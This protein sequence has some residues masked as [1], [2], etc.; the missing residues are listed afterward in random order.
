MKSFDGVLIPASIIESEY[1]ATDQAE[2]TAISSKTAQLEAE[3]ETVLEDQPEDDDLFT[4]VLSST[5][6]VIEKQ[7]NARITTLDLLKKSPELAVIDQIIEHFTAKRQHEVT[8]L[9]KQHPDFA[10]LDIYGKTG[11]PIKTKLTAARAQLAADA[12]VP[13]PY[14]EE[15]EALAGYAAK[16][17]ELKALKKQAKEARAALDEK[18]K[19][20]YEELATDEIKHLL[21]DLKWVAHICDTVSSLYDQEINSYASRITD[22]AKR[23]ERTLPSIEER[24]QE[25]RETMM[26]N[27][28]RMGYAW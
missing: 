8:R 6:K 10:S 24:V 5:G 2:L 21:F 15:Y 19:A 17:D 25:S 3:L 27:L 1:F 14:R 28:E 11:K 7:L 4:E 26:R 22:I 12:P 9:L 16:N 23:Y 20:K 18:V 13:E